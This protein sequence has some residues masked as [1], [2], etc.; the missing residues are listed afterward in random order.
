MSRPA[1]TV[2]DVSNLC[3]AK[4]KLLSNTAKRNPSFAEF[5]NRIPL[6]LRHSRIAVGRIVGAENR[7][8]VPNI[9]GVRYGIEVVR[10]VIV[11]LAVQMINFHAVRNGAVKGLV[12]QAM[13]QFMRRFAGKTQSRAHVAVLGLPE[14]KHPLLSESPS[15]VSLL[16]RFNPTKA[17]NCVLKLAAKNRAPNFVAVSGHVHIMQ[18]AVSAGNYPST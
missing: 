7:L 13:N 11:T 8:A 4:A 5:K 16:D 9:V 6:L 17:G 1:A 15:K 2:V 10:S 14:D 18:Q 3:F 12:D